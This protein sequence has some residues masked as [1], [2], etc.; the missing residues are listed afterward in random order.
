MMVQGY[1]LSQVQGTL[2]DAHW[3]AIATSGIKFVYLRAGVGNDANDTHF[4]AYQAGARNAGIVVGAYSFGYLIPPDPAHPGREPE[5]Q[6]QRHYEA[7]GGLGSQ[8]GDLPMAL[9][10]EWPDPSQWPKWGVD[11]SFCVDWTLAYLAKAATLYQRQLSI[12]IAPWFASRINLP[13][14]VTNCALWLAEYGPPNPKAPAP[15]STW[16]IHQ[17]SDGG[18]KLLNGSPVD[19]NVCEDATLAALLA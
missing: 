14:S 10:L 8:S 5:V 15:W 16:A 13:A 2:T 19:Q 3:S 9:D 4:E 18:A 17:Y 11:E 7:C 6:A 12:Y 1:D